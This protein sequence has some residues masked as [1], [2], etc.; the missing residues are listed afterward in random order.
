[1]SG[2][3]CPIA[4]LP[5]IRSESPAFDLHHPEIAALEYADN[6]SLGDSATPTDAPDVAGRDDAIGH[7][8]PDKD[9]GPHDH[10]PGSDE[11][12]DA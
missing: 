4:S 12:K 1:L 2:T 6:P 3:S 7:G 8:V 9:T 10:R 11:G 5:R